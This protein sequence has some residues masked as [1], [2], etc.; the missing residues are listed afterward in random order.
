MNAG[1]VNEKFKSEGAKNW[2]SSNTLEI[3]VL[4]LIKICI[5]HILNIQLEFVL[6]H[7]M[8]KVG[9]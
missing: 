9:V 8:L 3:F 4:R 5:L 1:K 7:T 6:G 2:W